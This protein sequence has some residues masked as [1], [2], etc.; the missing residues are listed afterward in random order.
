MTCVF[1]ALGVGLA[2]DDAPSPP[3][4]PS[5]LESTGDDLV[6]L[7]PRSAVAAAEF[8]DV[9]GR[10]D[11]LRAIAPLARLQDRM[12][13]RLDLTAN[14]VPAI[15]GTRAALAFV[16]DGETRR[17]VPL[18]VLDPPSPA[19]AAARLRRSG[20]L[21]VVESRG[22]L[23]VGPA[24]QLPLLERVAAGDGTSFRQAVNFMALT[25]R[26]PGGGLVRVAINPGALREYLR[27]RAEVEGSSLA[28][29]LAAL[30]R[31][32]LESVDVMGF[33]RDIAGGT[34]NTAG[35]IGLNT[36]LVAPAVRDAMAATRTP[37]VLPP[38]LPDDW[39]SVKSFRVEAEAGLAWLQ[40]L[41]VRDP[42]G[43]LRNLEFWL[44]EFEQ[45]TGRDVER[46]LVAPLGERGLV[47]M[48]AGG[49][50]P[51]IDVVAIIDA[52]DPPRLQ[53]SLVD[54]CDWLGE[55]VWGRSL[56]LVRPRTSQ[57]RS[58]DDVVHGIEFRSLVG[59]FKGPVF[60]LAG[61][62]L[63]IALGPDALQLGVELAATKDEWTTPAWAEGP[64]GPADEIAWI[65]LSAL[66]DV[67]RAAPV[68][69]GDELWFADAVAEFLDGDGD[70][71]LTVFWEPQGFSI[72]GQLQISG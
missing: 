43:P 51:V 13:A 62:H 59:S 42:S 28:G 17:L 15:A 69:A 33:Q 49:T 9:A 39:L 72:A 50:D 32:D 7:L 31:A 21:A 22:A 56:G 20:A 2:C 30:L 60:Q 67:L 34:I 29:Q 1:V 25:E 19:D 63:V 46:D 18:A 36:E 35:W 40:A 55:Q 71:R 8:R 66:G 37:P 3:P 45:R 53:A 6:A 26:L 70:G 16:I 4:A 44:S 68:F 5:S 23:W 38:D 12:L 47:L 65:R 64:E 57:A 61:D 27:L 52:D 10:W 11:E 58:G 48:L 14:D 41:A 54:L 24:G